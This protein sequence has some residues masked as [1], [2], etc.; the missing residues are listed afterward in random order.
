MK[1]YKPRISRNIKGFND[2]IRNTNAYLNA[3]SPLPSI[4]TN[5][6]RLG[7]LPA[8]ITQWGVFLSDGYRFLRCIPTRRQPVQQK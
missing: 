4:V 8:E 7:I 3:Q 2:D 5:G 1:V 6:V